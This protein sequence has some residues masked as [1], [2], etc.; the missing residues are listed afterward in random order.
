MQLLHISLTKNDFEF[1][2]KFYLHTK[3]TAS[4]KFAPAYANIY[5]AEWKK[6][7]FL[8]CDKIPLKY[9]RYLDDI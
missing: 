9:Y 8:K 5:M 3:G 6:T 2:G 1:D 4:K 7:A